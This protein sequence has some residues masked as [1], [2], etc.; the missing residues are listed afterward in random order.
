MSGDNS[1]RALGSGF[2]DEF[3]SLWASQSEQ[4]KRSTQRV[5]LLGTSKVFGGLLRFLGSQPRLLAQQIA[6]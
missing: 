4:R 5:F 3:E 1:A 2:A 6:A